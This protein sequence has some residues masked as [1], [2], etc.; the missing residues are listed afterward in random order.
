MVP[1]RNFSG[2]AAALGLNFYC[3]VFQSISSIPGE[4]PLKIIAIRTVAAKG[5]LVEQTLD[6][7]AGTNLI[8]TSLGSDRPAHPPVPATPKENRRARQPS[9]HQRPQPARTLPLR[10]FRFFLHYQPERALPPPEYDVSR[11][12]AIG[13]KP[14]GHCFAVRV[15]TF[16]ST[17]TFVYLRIIATR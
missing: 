14:G 10:R 13:F 3:L 6:S 7:A 4:Q 2:G 15:A 5:I 11:G 17:V 1:E 8:G 12:R 9:G 16:S